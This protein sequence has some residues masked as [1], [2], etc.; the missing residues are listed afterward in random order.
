VY[1]DNRWFL[2]VL[3]PCTH[4][5]KKNRCGIYAQRPALCRKYSTK[6]CDYIG[7]EEFDLHLRNI[8]DVD[9]YVSK[10]W[11]NTKAARTS[12]KKTHH[13]TRHLPTVYLRSVQV[14]EPSKK[15]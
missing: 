13:T 4:L 8:E 11:G 12:K 14:R 3:S 9:K 10:R 7:E 6:D 5:T 1:D 15:K 2:Y